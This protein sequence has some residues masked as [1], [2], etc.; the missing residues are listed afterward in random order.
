MPLLGMEHVVDMPGCMAELG[1]RAEWLY[2]VNV[3]AI[4]QISVAMA[5]EYSKYCI[6]LPMTYMLYKVLTF[7]LLSFSLEQ[8]EY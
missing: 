2:I 1:G 6:I 5:Q 4:A 3:D 7:C 8:W